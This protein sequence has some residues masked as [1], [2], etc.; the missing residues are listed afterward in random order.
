MATPKSM[1][2]NVLVLRIWSLLENLIGLV[3]DVPWYFW[4]LHHHVTG[5]LIWQASQEVT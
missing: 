5:S 4:R 1:I 3:L 2:A